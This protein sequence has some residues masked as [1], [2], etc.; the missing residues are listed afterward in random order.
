MPPPLPDPPQNN[1]VSFAKKLFR[2]IILLTLCSVY[3]GLCASLYA[4][5]YAVFMLFDYAKSCKNNQKLNTFDYASFMR[6]IPMRRMFQ[7]LLYAG[8]M[9]DF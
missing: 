3:T 7:V 6:V 2:I 5:L 1:I 4:R 9:R 8:F